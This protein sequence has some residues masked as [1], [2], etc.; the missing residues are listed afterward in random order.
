MSDPNKSQ[1]SIG[2]SRMVKITHGHKD[3]LDKLLKNTIKTLQDYRREF[4]HKV[5]QNDSEGLDLLIHTSTM[6]LYYIEAERL[7][8]LMRQTKQ[9]LAQ[10]TDKVGLS[11]SIEETLSEFKAVMHNLEKMDL[12]QVL[13]EHSR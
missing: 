3:K 10:K 2:L 9:F 12:D 5:E 1:G 11:T 4:L 8:G 6:T 7:D 13:R